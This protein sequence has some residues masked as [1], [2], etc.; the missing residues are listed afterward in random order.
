MKT[1]F[2]SESTSSLSTPELES[3]QAQTPS[4][5]PAI[6]VS[7][8]DDATGVAM[9][10][11]AH[12]RMLDSAQD[13]TGLGFD[14]FDQDVWAKSGEELSIWLLGK[15]YTSLRRLGPL[16]KA[17]PRPSQSPTLLQV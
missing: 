11:V 14:D 13:M 16:S 5:P 15:P 10:R 17:A 8:G 7:D 3:N 2:R 12:M 4:R 6:V 9:G 1:F